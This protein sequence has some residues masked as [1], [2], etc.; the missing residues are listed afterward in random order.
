MA[1][2]ARMTKLWAEATVWVA[3]RAEAATRA[4]ATEAAIRVEVEAEARACHKM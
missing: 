1:I 3:I 4:E 2:N